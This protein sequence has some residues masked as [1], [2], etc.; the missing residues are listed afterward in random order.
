MKLIDELTAIAPKISALEQRAEEAERKLREADA[1]FWVTAD[2]LIAATTRAEEAEAARDGLYKESMAFFERAQ[3]AERR[4]ATIAAALAGKIAAP[5]EIVAEATAEVSE[6]PAEPAPEPTEYTD[7]HAAIL[8]GLTHEFQTVLEL[9]KSAKVHGFSKGDQTVRNYMLRDIMPFADKRGTIVQRDKPLAWKL[10]DKP[11]GNKPED[12]KPKADKAENADV[13]APRSP[14]GYP[15]YDYALTESAN[16]RERMAWMEKHRKGD[17]QTGRAQCQCCYGE[18]QANDGIIRDHGHKRNDGWNEGAC[19]GS[20][21]MP[22]NLDY[23]ALMSL[24][25]FHIP[26]ELAYHQATVAMIDEDDT[27][28]K[29]GVTFTRDTYAEHLIG[30]AINEYPTRI[31]TVIKP[32]LLEDRVSH[33]PDWGAFKTKIRKATRARIKELREELTFRKARLANWA[34]TPY[35]HWGTRTA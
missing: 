23:R 1:G 6:Y 35:K 20:G 15:D 7:D 8:K 12:D 26:N 17:D 32:T 19:I 2:D 14:E 24:I 10:T 22:L 27:V 9:H 16:G 4:L 13:E 33:A 29:E 11:N 31:P 34:P 25:N 3:S 28:R 18:Y 21:Q 30:K 5:V